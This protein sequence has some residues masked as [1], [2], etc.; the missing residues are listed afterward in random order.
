MT[1][2]CKPPSNHMRVFGPSGNPQA[3]NLFAVIQ[4]LQRH[5]GVRLQ[6]LAVR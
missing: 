6:V 1:H 5:E 2:R 4:Q 3:R